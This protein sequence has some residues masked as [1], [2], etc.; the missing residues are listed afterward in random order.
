MDNIRVEGGVPLSG[1]VRISGAKN[2]ALPILTAALLAD[3]AHTFRNV[4]DLRDVH[5]ML[6]MLRRLGID[7]EYER[8]VA[9]V[10]ARPVLEPVAP[11]DLVKQMRASVLVL[12]PLVARYGRAS[13]SLPGGCA[14]GAR[15]IDQHLRGLE[16]MG[17]AVRLE[18]GYVHVDVP[19]GRLRGADIYLDF[20]TVTGTENLLA[21]AALAEG[22]TTIGNAAREPEIEELAH[23][24][25][26]MGASVDGAGTDS[27]SRPGCGSCC[28]LPSR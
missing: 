12:G 27:R 21:A 14:I 3:G 4:P 8:G 16:A 7:A 26:K 23:V 10:Q 25:N 2:A 5:T 28:S 15:P 13:V 18:H 20:P 6:R 1:R 19:S 11:Y 22:R 9:T 24:L 17:A